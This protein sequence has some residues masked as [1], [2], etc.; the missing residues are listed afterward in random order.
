MGQ[1]SAIRRDQRRVCVKG[2]Q[3]STAGMGKGLAGLSGD[4]GSAISRDQ[5]LS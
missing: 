1:G 5:R 4:L 2:L 3:G